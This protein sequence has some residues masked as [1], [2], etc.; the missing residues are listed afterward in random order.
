MNKHHLVGG[1]LLLLA[2]FIIF[3]IG[4]EIPIASKSIGTVNVCSGAPAGTT[5]Y[6]YSLIGRF[7]DGNL[8]DYRRGVANPSTAL[9]CVGQ[10]RVAAEADLYFW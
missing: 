7:G 8:N 6:H 9:A 2:I 4:L 1:L 5:S 10:K 3:I